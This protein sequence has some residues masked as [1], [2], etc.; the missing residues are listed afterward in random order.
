M[1]KKLKILLTENISTVA[2]DALSQAGFEVELRK[3]A[4]SPNDLITA[5]KDVSALGIRSKTQVTPEVLKA[6]PQLLTVGC[7]CIGTNQVDLKTAKLEGIPIFNAPFS[8]TRS[9]AEMTIS[10]I[11]ALSRKIEM[12]NREMHQGNWNKESEGC[13]EVRGK[14]LGIIGYGNIGTQVSMMAENLGMRVVFYD[15]ITKLTLG[16]AMPAGSLGELYAESDFITLH[17]PETEITKNMISHAEI[18][19]MKKGAYILNA[20]RGMVLDIAALAQALESNH[21]GGASIDVFPTEPSGKTE[22]FKTPL[23]GIPNVIL[24]PHIG[25]ATEEAQVNIGSEVAHTL[26]RFLKAGATRGAVNFPTLDAPRVANANRILNVHKNVPGVLKDINRI[27]AETGANILGQSLTTD[28]ELGYLSIDLDM[29]ITDAFVLKI[30]SAP[31]MIRTRLA[32]K[33]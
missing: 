15:I 33:I 1:K 5:L 20:S 6:T 27:I 21:L 3:N 14:T 9:V 28:S 26:I 8:N 31:N 4:L 19:S 12:R 2:G 25:G 13:Y 11:I 18:K 29:D 16:N 32:P 24:T 30:N 23:A 7:F 17:V 22:P 10:N